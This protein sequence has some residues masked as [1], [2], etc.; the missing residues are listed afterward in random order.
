VT[1]VESVNGG[2]SGRC[3][4]FWNMFVKKKGNFDNERR[5][6]GV[7]IDLVALFIAVFFSAIESTQL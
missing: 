5:E 3:G 1:K 6:G 4:G 2:V 7:I